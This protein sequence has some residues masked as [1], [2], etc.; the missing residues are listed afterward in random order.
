MAAR[1]AFPL[2]QT[3][4]SRLSIRNARPSAQRSVLARGGA[5]KDLATIEEYNEFIAQEGVVVVDFFVSFI[6]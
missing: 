1:I 2:Q 3:R 6:F 5:V 4:V